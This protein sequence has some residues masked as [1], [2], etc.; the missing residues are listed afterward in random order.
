MLGLLAGLLSCAAVA[1]GGPAHENRRVRAGDYKA[2]HRSWWFDA[3]FGDAEKQAQLADL[4]LGPHGR[5]AGAPRREGV[6]FLF[7]AAVAGRPA[8]MLHLADA[9]GKGAFGL[10]KLFAAARCHRRRARIFRLA[11]P[12]YETRK[13]GL[14]FRYRTKFRIKA[15]QVT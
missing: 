15:C 6:R 4:L 1:G 14:S 7:R 12:S 5:E 3:Q 2:L 9:L 11:H 13:P 8:A 10:G